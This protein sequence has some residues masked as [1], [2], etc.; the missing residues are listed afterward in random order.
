VL[1]RSL[2]LAL[3]GVSLALAG[4]VGE[5]DA[6]H[7]AVAA[8][9]AEPAREI[10]E[11][12]TDETGARVVVSFAST[13]QLFTQ[14]TQDAPF[15]VFLSADQDAPA[16]LVSLGLADGNSVITYAVGELALYSTSLDLTDGEAVLSEGAF[17]HLALADPARAPYG[18][19]AI[20]TL[21]SLDL[22]ERLRGRFVQGNSVA[23]AFEFVESG[24]AELGF[25][26]LSQV[27]RAPSGSV[28][29]VPPRLHA[30]IRQDAVLVGRG[31]GDPD[32][33]AFL[34][35]LK[36]PK[37]IDVIRKYGYGT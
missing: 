35:F 10:A 16:G 27:V 11:V 29:R 2:I 5:D 37:A 18:A 19:A 28:W 33:A 15:E 32:A 31:V 13:Q 8:N 12:F 36:S 34:R 21:M 25:V 4:C 3:A 14:M 1:R 20:E 7:V 6:L 30:A 23:Q 9:F 24:N 17:S 22:W 26:A